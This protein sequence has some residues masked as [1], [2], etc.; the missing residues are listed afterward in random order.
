M[1]RRV[2]RLEVDHEAVGHRDQLVPDPAQGV[3]VRVDVRR[4]P[5]ELV[6]L[7][8]DVMAKYV[9]KLLGGAR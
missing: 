6:N 2:E 1:Q 3:P 8:V 9:E 5:G 7:E 4:Q